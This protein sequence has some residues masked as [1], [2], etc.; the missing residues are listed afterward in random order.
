[1]FMSQPIN[2]PVRIFF[3]KNLLLK[4]FRSFFFV[5]YINQYTETLKLIPSVIQ[6]VHKNSKHTHYT[7]IIIT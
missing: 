6:R 2:I 7:Q 3:L 5:V 4:Y 1:M